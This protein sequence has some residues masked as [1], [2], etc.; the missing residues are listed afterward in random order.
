MRARVLG[1][2][3][4]QFRIGALDLFNLFNPFNTFSAE[5]IQ[6]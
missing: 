3:I 5:F 2:W 1:L 6:P 4:T